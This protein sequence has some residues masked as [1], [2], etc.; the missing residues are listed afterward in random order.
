MQVYTAAAKQLEHLSVAHRV[1]V[2]VTRNC[3]VWLKASCG[4]GKDVNLHEWDRSSCHVLS[5]SVA[6]GAEV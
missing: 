2:I 5:S 3:P 4:Q 6:A 1:S